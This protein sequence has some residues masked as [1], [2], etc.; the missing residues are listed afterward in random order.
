MSKL[1]CE[2][3]ATLLVAAIVELLFEI[4]ESSDDEAAAG[5]CW[6]LVRDELD[7]DEDDGWIDEEDDECE[8]DSSKESKSFGVK[9]ED[10]DEQGE[11][12][13]EDSGSFFTN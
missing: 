6:L 4:D 12:E 11:H 9:V 8:D 10:E 2:F 1:I 5:F 7:V 13:G 3:A